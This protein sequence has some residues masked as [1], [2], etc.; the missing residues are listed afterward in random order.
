MVVKEPTEDTVHRQCS[1]C[2]IRQVQSW[3]CEHIHAEPRMPKRV[4]HTW[5]H[6][7]PT[8]VLCASCYFNQHLFEHLW[9]VLFT[10]SPLSQQ[11]CHSEVNE[12]KHGLIKATLVFAM[13][14]ETCRSQTPPI[15]QF[16]NRSPSWKS[17]FPFDFFPSILCFDFQVCV[18][19]FHVW[20]YQLVAG[21]L[22]FK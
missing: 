13:N 15:S 22:H 19:R 17:A 14:R 21:R 2:Y 6:S 3:F 16:P 10:G 18:F 5:S 12:T 8:C 4:L 9:R 7:G 11:L 1:H 20:I